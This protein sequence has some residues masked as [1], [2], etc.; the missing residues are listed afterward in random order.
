MRKVIVPWDHDAEDLSAF[1]MAISRRQP[2]DDE[3]VPALRDT[4]GGRRV[5]WARFDSAPATADVW[6]RHRGQV[7]QVRA[8]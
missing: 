2:A 8:V 5:L 7:T 1:H 3:W 6:V 4:I